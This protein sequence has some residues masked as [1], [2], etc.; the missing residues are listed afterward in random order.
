MFDLYYF[1]GPFIL[2]LI[3]PFLCTGLY[4]AIF[5]NI[6]PNSIYKFLLGPVALLGFYI[7]AVPMKMGFYEFFRATF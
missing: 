6:L 1:I 2:L 7:W 5:S 4:A 3:I